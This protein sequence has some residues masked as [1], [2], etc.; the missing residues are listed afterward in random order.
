MTEISMMILGPFVSYFVASGFYLSGI[1]SILT[2]GVFLSYYAKP[3]ISPAARKIV[4]MLY[5]VVA[6]AA[7]T[8][9][10]LFLGMGLFTISHPL[11]TMGFGVFITT[12]LNLNVARLLN[13]GIVSFLV[14]LQRTEKTKISYKTQFVMWFS[15]LRGAMAYA[16]AL[17]AAAELPVGQIILIDTL[18]YSLVT[19][20][21]FGSVLHPI[22]TKMEVK[23][24][25]RVL[26]ED[27]EVNDNCS[28]RFK[29][30]LALFDTYYFAPLFIKDSRNIGD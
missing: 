14:Y 28:N 13:V 12:V 4:K 23:N 8:T 10:F 11:K 17:E 29:K 5:G 1:V 19:I 22:L 27:E 25:P 21:G 18:T 2:N 16:L 9:V 30:R 24:K 15:G 26:G 20:L 3:N 6:H 7:E